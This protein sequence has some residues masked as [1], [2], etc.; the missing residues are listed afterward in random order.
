M[1]SALVRKSGSVFCWYFS[2]MALTDSASILA[3]AGLYTPH[4]R[5]QCASAVAFGAR[6]RAS[7]LMMSFS[8]GGS[9]DHGIRQYNFTKVMVAEGACIGRYGGSPLLSIRW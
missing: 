2:Q 7:S 5:S 1:M 6:A 8:R 9:F 4:G 3:W